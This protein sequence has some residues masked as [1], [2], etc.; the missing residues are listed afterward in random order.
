MT[1]DSIKVPTW[2][3]V[4]LQQNNN[5][6]DDNNSSDT[7]NDNDNNIN[8]NNSDFGRIFQ[9]FVYSNNNPK[10]SVTKSW[11]QFQT[12][13]KQFQYCVKLW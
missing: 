12:C 3:F 10:M 5:D 11:F 4:I 13:V 6:N 8:D 7:S 9:T 2:G 1:K